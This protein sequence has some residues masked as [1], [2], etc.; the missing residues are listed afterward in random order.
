MIKKGIHMKRD[1]DLIRAILLVIEAD[2]QEY[3]ASLQIN[4]Y[5]QEQINYHAVL[6][7]EAGFAKII[8]IK[9][10]ESAIP[11]KV[12]IERLTWTGYEFLDAA[13]DRSLW[14][15]AK[16][17]VG[18]ATIQIWMSVLTALTLKQLGL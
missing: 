9:T 7:G 18:S 8:E 17:K 4:G 11:M 6:L 5:T 10:E 3:V 15:Q 16:D 1:M 13:R 12:I 14:N 2:E